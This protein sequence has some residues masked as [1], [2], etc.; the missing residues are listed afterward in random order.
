MQ[1]TFHLQL[2]P[3][4]HHRCHQDRRG[5]SQPEKTHFCIGNHQGQ[6]C[7]PLREHVDQ[8]NG[9]TVTETSP[10]Q[11]VV[12]MPTIGVKGGTPLAETAHDHG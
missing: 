11:T 9:A 12:E 3:A 10:Q 8:E 4:D 6:S 5:E 7:Q 1:S 2:T